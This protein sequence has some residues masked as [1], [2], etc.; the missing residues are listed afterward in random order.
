M[1][2]RIRAYEMQDKQACLALFDSN[3]PRFFAPSERNDFAR[4]LEKAAFACA[5]RVIERAGR[6]AGC[7]GLAIE[8]DGVTAT[9]CWGM[10]DNALHRQGLGRLLTEIRLR[11]ARET[12]GI[13]YVRVNTS[14][15]T[16]DFYARFGFVTEKV[17]PDGYG[18]GLD[19]WDMALPLF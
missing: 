15:H 18:P 10:I 17:T 3:V 4:F 16:R 7:G 11:E 14:Q 8:T 12:P 6:L 1:T 19:R 13:R 5:Y 2:D 9:L